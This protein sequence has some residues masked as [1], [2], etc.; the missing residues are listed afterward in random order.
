MP[1]GIPAERVTCNMSYPFPPPHRDMGQESAIIGS[2]RMFM[3]DDFNIVRISILGQDYLQ[4]CPSLM[5][6]TGT[7]RPRYAYSGSL[8]VSQPFLVQMFG[9]FSESFSGQFLTS[10]PVNLE[11]DHTNAAHAF[12]V[13]RVPGIDSSRNG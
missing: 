13:D 2:S 12:D 7:A 5:E 11:H 3:L 8:L 10:T 6:W 4:Y 1:S 9:L